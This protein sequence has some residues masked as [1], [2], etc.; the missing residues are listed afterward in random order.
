MLT[1]VSNQE[2]HEEDR[3]E[4]LCHFITN[5]GSPARGAR[6]L[7]GFEEEVKATSQP[8]DEEEASFR[9]FAASQYQAVLNPSPLATREQVE[10]CRRAK[11]EMEKWRAM[12]GAGWKTPAEEG[13][14]AFDPKARPVDWN[15]KW[16]PY[17]SGTVDHDEWS[18]GYCNAIDS[19]D[20]EL[21]DAYESLDDELAAEEERRA[22]ESSL[23]SFFAHVERLGN[24]SDNTFL[25][26]ATIN[27]Q[28]FI[29]GSTLM[30]LEHEVGKYLPDDLRARLLDLGNQLGQES[31]NR[32]VERVGS[33]ED[34]LRDFKQLK[35]D[36]KILGT[37]IAA[38]NIMTPYGVIEDDLYHFWHVF[39]DKRHHEWK[40]A[41]QQA[42][43]QDP[44]KGK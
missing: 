16:N 5:S 19:S 21:A 28:M 31:Q 12:Y 9:R 32:E 39:H 11:E 41:Q 30:M 8:K 2:E 20:A 17:L 43:R 26:L 3:Y 35:T 18:D 6:Y 22:R 34:R 44:K 33:V 14:D 15:G 1:M 29:L 25:T 4:S 27:G 38:R 7:L 23:D 42:Q 37:V 24:S 40:Q 13:Y 36:L 10:Y